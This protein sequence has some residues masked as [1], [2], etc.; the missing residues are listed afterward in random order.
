MPGI[1]LSK[2]KIRSYYRQLNNLQDSVQVYNFSST[3][4]SDE[5]KLFY[6]K[7]YTICF[8]TYYINIIEIILYT[9]LNV[10]NI[11]NNKN[12]LLKICKVFNYINN[13][14]GKW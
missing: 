11:N 14:I 4:L 7:L 10:K 5:P 9:I 12:K 3:M 6:Y 13:N 8:I 2:I 1:L